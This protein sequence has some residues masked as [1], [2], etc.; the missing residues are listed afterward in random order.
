MRC[1][2]LIPRLLAAATLAFAQLA[3]AQAP[4]APGIAVVVMHGKGGSPARHVNGLASFLEQRGYL[5]ANLEMPWSGRREYDVPVDAAEKEVDA[6]LDAM[7]ARGAG[8]VFVAGHSQGA[9]SRCT[10]AASARWTA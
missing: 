8:K 5:V 9:C 4:A 2:R 3:P 1:I 6:A 10:T 7:R